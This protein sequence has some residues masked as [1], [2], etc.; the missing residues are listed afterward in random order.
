MYHCSQV[1]SLSRS[2]VRH[3]DH[4]AAI[5]ILKRAASV[6]R[7]GVL[8]AVSPDKPDKVNSGRGSVY[9]ARIQGRGPREI[10]NCR[11]EDSVKAKNKPP[12]IRLYESVAGS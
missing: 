6:L 4:N 1:S 7:G 5:N 12:L 8:V 9:R 2:G 3:R 11:K 10:R